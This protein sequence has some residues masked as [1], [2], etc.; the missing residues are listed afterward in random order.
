MRGSRLAFL[1][2]PLLV[3]ALAASAAAESRKTSC[4]SSGRVF[5]FEIPHSGPLLIN[6]TWPKATNDSDIAVFDVE[7]NLIALGLSVEPR[8]EQVV[9]GGLPF[10]VVDILVAKFGGP[11]SGCYLYV[12]SSDGNLSTA[13]S[14][15]GK[16]RYRGSLTELAARDER[17]AKMLE[18]FERAVAAKRAPRPTEE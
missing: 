18:S 1:L 2:S 9:L 6:L 4:N 7:G 15:A 8:F 14:G 17:Y 16:L 3:V 5:G 13:A 12:G 11:N 10:A